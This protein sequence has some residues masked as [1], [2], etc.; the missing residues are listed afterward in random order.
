MA[1]DSKALLALV[2]ALSSVDNAAQLKYDNTSSGLLSTN[3]EDAI[4]EVASSVGNIREE[5]TLR[6][7]P[8]GGDLNNYQSTGIWYAVTSAVAATIQNTPFTAGAFRLEVKTITS[9]RLVQIIY[10]NTDITRF[11]VRNLSGTGWSAWRRF[12]GVSAEA[13]VYGS[14][15]PINANLND[16]TAIGEYYIGSTEIAVSLTNTPNDG[17]SITAHLEVQGLNIANNTRL[18]QIYTPNWATSSEAGRYYMRQL[19]SSGWTRWYRFGGEG[20]VAESE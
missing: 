1:T 12:N 17:A 7:I 15:I 16:F 10:P 9:G 5:L 11:Y 13:S 2:A 6:A 14:A 19:I 18:T 3:V 8:E 20:V 4:N